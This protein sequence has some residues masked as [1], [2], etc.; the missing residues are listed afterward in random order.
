MY[1]GE[2]PMDRRLVLYV[3]TCAAEPTVELPAFVESA[4]AQGWDTCVIA[5]PEAARFFDTDQVA[6]MTGHPVRT[7][8]KD[9]EQPDVLPPPEVL[10]L[11]PATFNTINKLAAGISDTL[12]LALL[13]EAIG[14]RLPVIAA[15][16]VNAALGSHP[17]FADSIA[18]LRGW[19]VRVIGGTGPRGDGR[20]AEQAVFPWDDLT[21]ELARL[22]AVGS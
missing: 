3:I 20:P 22:R 2:E 5:T 19:G 18:R 4:L 1:S 11:A 8:F 15:P 17:A 14:L 21:A 10:L 6:E 9:P 7:R 12:A 13:N 16:W